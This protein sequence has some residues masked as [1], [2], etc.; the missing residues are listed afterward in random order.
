MLD[1]TNVVAPR[2]VVAERAKQLADV[3]RARRGNAVSPRIGR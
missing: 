2:V 3:L 1:G